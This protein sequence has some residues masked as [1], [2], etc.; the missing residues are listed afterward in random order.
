MILLSIG[1]LLLA[2]RLLG[3][4]AR[5]C[6]QPALV[7]ELLAGVLL[8]PTV[9]GHWAPGTEAA[10]FPADGARAQALSGVTALAAVLFL[11]VVG[12]EISLG[13]IL[14]QG[15]TALAVSVGGIALPF[16]LGYGA[17]VAAPQLLGMSPGADAAVFALF[18]ATAMAISA[19]PVI[20]RTL[21]DLGLLRSELGVVVIAA[22]ICNDLVGWTVFAVVMGLISAG[23][24]PGGALPVPAT[25]ALTLLVFAVALTAG[26][27]LAHRALRW[28]EA[29]LPPDGALGVLLALGLLAGA[30][31]EA[32]GLHA[33]LG[34]FLVGVVTGDSP[35][36][37]ARTR[38]VL[39]QFVTAFFAPLLFAAVGLRV[40]ALAS[41][42]PATVGAVLAIAC[43]GKVLGCAAAARLAGMAP[44]VAWAVGFA[45][46]SRGMMEI[47][48]GTV[49][50]QA[51]VINERTYVALVVMALVTSAV[52]GPLIQRALRGVPPDA[53][54]VRA[55]DAARPTAGPA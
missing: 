44:R 49:A 41:F 4:L 24:H 20:A 53:A 15:R 23:A 35:H 26:R 19:L 17:A 5:R 36:L 33:I 50:L 12:M 13:A 52:A 42:D 8:G 1:V 47:V 38:L 10:L 6:R 51:G 25:V 46:N 22:A 37:R 30:L 7:G 39:E 16:A 43:T 18:F 14:R 28:S 21:L 27:W 31:L 29:R 2:A 11:L 9:L 3:E 32:I 54:G 55:H 40:D 34:A 45:L 48:L